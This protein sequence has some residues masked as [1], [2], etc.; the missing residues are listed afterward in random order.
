MMQEVAVDAVLISAPNTNELPSAYAS[1]LAVEYAATANEDHKKTFGQFF[2]PIEIGNYLASLATF[3]GTEVRLLDPGCGTGVLACAL[4]EHL[5]RTP[6]QLTAI[7][8]DAYDVDEGVQPYTQAVL[9]YLTTWLHGRN[10]TCHCQLV[11]RDFIH[12]HEDL[13]SFP[14]AQASPVYDLVI[15]NPPYFKLSATDPRN[16]LARQRQ[17]DQPNIYSLFIVQAA[18]LTKPGG[19]LI[20]I[21]PRSFC[22]GPYFERFRRFAFEHLSFDVFHLFHS[23]SKAF[24]KDA[25]LQEN[26]IFKATRVATTPAPTYPVQVVASEAGHDLAGAPK[27][28]CTLQELVDLGSREQ[29]LFLPTSA[30][31][32][33]LIADFKN[34]RHR[35]K[36]F[37]WEVSTG[38]VVA[39]RTTEYLHETPSPDRVPLFWID[40]V[41]RGMI[42]WP[43]TRGRHQYLDAAGGKK[44]GLLPSRNYVLLRRFS[45]KDDKHRLIAA[46][47]YADEWAQYATVGLE[48]KLNYIYSPKGALTIEQ[49]TGLTALLNSNL[50]DAFFRIFNGNTQVSATEARALPMPPLAAIEEIGRRMQ[51]QELEAL[52]SI[53]NDV[54]HHPMDGTLFPEEPIE[55][56]ADLQKIKESTEILKAL[57]LPRAQLNDRS[58]LTLLALLDLKPEG[59]WQQ[60]HPRHMGVT[61]IMDWCRINYGRDYA[62][63]TRET[64]RRQTLHQF[65]AC[66]IVI[67]NEDDPARP[68]NSPHA[69]YLISPELRHVLEQFSTPTWDEELKQYLVSRPTLVQ[70]YAMAREMTLIPL[71]IS[72]DLSLNLS[73]GAHSQLIGQIVT[74]FGPRFAPDAEV[75]YLGDTGGKTDYFNRERLKELG[76]EVDKHGK[77][78]DVVLYFGAKNWLLLIEAVTSH[79]PVD[80][81]RHK[82]LSDLFAKNTTDGIV[83][84]TAF[85]DKRTMGRYLSDISWETEVW[86]AEAP[87]HMIHFNGVRFLGPYGS[88]PAANNEAGQ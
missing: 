4:V 58:A 25:V 63:N 34:W 12:E 26:M 38:P 84:V 30:A 51:G 68:V 42:D 1:R 70:Q 23:R 47:Y 75:I 82:E 33:T 14:L 55:L 17:H 10:I 79:G 48:N 60:L 20:F 73:S 80:G 49:T 59:S 11:P 19:E 54:L 16:A 81:K 66:G 62:P 22:S 88:N 65:Y 61:P 67:Y 28:A 64:F 57:G 29:V 35:L 40:H 13:W 56:T 53:V 74:E 27:Q 2:T 72:P 86:V 36:D 50:Y 87:T 32:R 37:G 39:F 9:D 83:Y 43:N 85:P 31:E 77:M 76:V 6:S 24:Q 21:V 46:A 41:R 15:S 71:R 52:N 8:L 3:T 5:V 69:N 78:P 7:T 18:L 44:G 45:A